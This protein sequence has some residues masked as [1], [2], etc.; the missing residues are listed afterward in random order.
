MLIVTQKNSINDRLST[1]GNVKT[2]MCV[3]SL[4]LGIALRRNTAALERFVHVNL[5]R[6][7]ISMVMYMAK[8][9]GACR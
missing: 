7:R 1:G 9:C 8:V 2:S 5:E 3:V 6:Q 4:I